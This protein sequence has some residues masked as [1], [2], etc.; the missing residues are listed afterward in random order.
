MPACISL[1]LQGMAKPIYYPA[2][3]TVS[4]PTCKLILAGATRRRA[5]RA[6][7]PCPLIPHRASRCHDQCCEQEAEGTW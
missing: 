7:A 2:S 5:S 1:P 4:P 3:N 6:E